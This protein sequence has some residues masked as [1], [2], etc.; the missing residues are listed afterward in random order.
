MRFP[1]E[2]RQRFD[3]ETVNADAQAS[4]DRDRPLPIPLAESKHA[5]LVAL[6]ATAHAPTEQS[7]ARRRACRDENAVD[8]LVRVPC[9]TA[10]L[11]NSSTL[12]KSIYDTPDSL[13]G[14]KDIDALVASTL[15]LQRQAGG[16]GFAPPVVQFGLPLTRYNRVEGFS[17]GI[18][19]DEDMG[20]GYAGHAIARLGIRSLAD[21]ELGVARTNGRE[22]YT[23]NVYRRLNSANDLAARPVQ[24]QRVT[25]CAVVRQR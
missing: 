15:S 2:L 10:A 7:I 16:V 13:F 12:P 5:E 4:A 9:D 22:T 1:F 3:Y 6:R 24:P 25:F 14:D 23:V 20:S 18:R 21:G 19:V 11:A 8:M 17:T